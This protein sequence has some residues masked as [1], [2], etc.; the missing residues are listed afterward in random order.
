MSD[1]L[2]ELPA[3][4]EAGT[5]VKLRRSHADYP[6]SAGWTLTLYLRGVGTLDAEAT[7]SG[8]DYL[9]TLAADDTA[10]LAAGTYRWVERVEKDGEVYTA[11]TG[12]VSVTLDLAVAEAGD[13][14]THAERTLALIEAALEGRI[15]QGMESYQVAG[16]AVT[17]IPIK[18]LADLRGIYAAKVWRERNAG[19]LLPAAQ[20]RFVNA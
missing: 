17:K 5:T 1:P 18:D 11:A 2:D 9:V 7:E 3:S 6:A 4:F 14:Q 13:A 10:A 8:D 16:R 20:L 12:V 15:P 19:K